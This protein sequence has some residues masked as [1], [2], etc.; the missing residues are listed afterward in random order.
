MLNLTFNINKH[1]NIN[2]NQTVLVNLKDLEILFD[3]ISH[4]DLETEI[5][6][7]DSYAIKNLLDDINNGLVAELN[8]ITSN[9]LLFFEKLSQINCR[10]IK[11]EEEISEII[12][13]E[14]ILSSDIGKTN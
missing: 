13:L 11:Q 12:K 6:N 5:N 3:R 7:F 2:D 9:L 14:K 4:L 8:Y 10:F 1:F